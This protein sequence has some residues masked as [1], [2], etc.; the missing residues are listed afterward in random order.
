MKGIEMTRQRSRRALL[1]KVS[2]DLHPFVSKKNKKH[3]KTPTAGS[4]SKRFALVYRGVVVS[5][6]AESTPPPHS[7]LFHLGGKPPL[8][9]CCSAARCHAPPVKSL[10]AFLLFIG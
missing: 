5:L 10:R 4:L 6:L 1:Y 7:G 9:F 2:F 3:Q 8:A